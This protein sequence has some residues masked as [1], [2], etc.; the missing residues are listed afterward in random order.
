MTEIAFPDLKLLGLFEIDESG[1]I[2]FAKS[3]AEERSTMA[4]EVMGKNLFELAPP[5]TVHDLHEN[6]RR[7]I[8]SNLQAD[9]F[10]VGTEKREGDHRVKVLLGRVRHRMQGDSYTSVLVQMRNV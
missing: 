10:Y 8:N 4:D 3:E 6:I 9:S 2:L 5:Q 7:F 1:T